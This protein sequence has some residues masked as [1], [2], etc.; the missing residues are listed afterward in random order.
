MGVT[1]YQHSQVRTRSRN[2]MLVLICRNEIATPRCGPPR[3]QCSEHRLSP[4]S[5]K[6]PSS[7]CGTPL[8][9]GIVRIPYKTLAAATVLA[10]R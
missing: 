5:R 3:G 8:R 2:R 10:L 4:P 9:P 6:V 7:G 1:R